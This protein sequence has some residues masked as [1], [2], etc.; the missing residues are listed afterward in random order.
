MRTCRSFL[1]T[2]RLISFFC[3]RQNKQFGY[4]RELAC[5]SRHDCDCLVCGTLGVPTC[6]FVPVCVVSVELGVWFQ[7]YFEVELF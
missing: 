7:F 2:Y 5:V 3:S 4:E 6:A 1:S